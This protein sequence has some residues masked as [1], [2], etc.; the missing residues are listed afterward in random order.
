MGSFL[1]TT[2]NGRPAAAGRALLGLVL[3]FVFSS[4]LL[5]PLALDQLPRLASAAGLL[6]AVVH[7]VINGGSVILSILITVATA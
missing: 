6:V 5:L 4:F 2:G 1:K 7:F 3:V